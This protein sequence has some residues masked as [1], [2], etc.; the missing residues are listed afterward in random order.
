MDDAK[1]AL[2]RLYTA[3]RGYEIAESPID[4]Q[5]PQAARFKVSL[6]DD[7]NTPEAMAV[8][9]DL[10]SELNKSKQPAT[11]DLLFNL[12]GVLGLLQQDANAFLQGGVIGSVNSVNNDDTATASGEVGYTEANINQLI[13]N[14]IDAKKAKNFADADRIRKQLADAGII[15]EDTPQGTTWRKA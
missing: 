7:F 4:W 5:H 6:D 15:L 8:L 2:T 9:F 10:A 14:R 11:A 13:S 3:L 12:A 1:L